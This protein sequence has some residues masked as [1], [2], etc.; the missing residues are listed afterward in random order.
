MRLELAQWK[1]GWD[2]LGVRGLPQIHCSVRWGK[3]AQVVFYISSSTTRTDTVP[4][5]EEALA[6]GKRKD[7]TWA[8]R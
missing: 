2:C 7:L 5:D 4:D 1:C 6:R 8:V 3:E